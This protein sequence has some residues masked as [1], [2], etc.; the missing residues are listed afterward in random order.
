MGEPVAVRSFSKINLGLRIGPPRADGFHHLTTLFQTVA[1]HDVVTVH[2]E[3]AAATEITLESNDPRVPRDARNTAFRMVAAALAAM[4]L[5][6]RVHVHLQKN[7]PPQGG[8]GAGSAN[9]AA[10]LLGLERQI[11]EWPASGLHFEDRGEEPILPRKSRERMGHPVHGSP[12]SPVGHGSTKRSLSGPERLRLA[13]S[14]GSDV[15][16]FLVG[17]TVYAHNRGELV[18]PYPDLPLMPCVVVSPGVGSSTPLAFRAWDEHMARLGAE[19]GQAR[20]DESS[21]VYASALWE[22]G[23][24]PNGSA[25][26]VPAETLAALVRLGIANDFEEVVFP[27]QPLLRTIKDALA[28]DGRAVLAMLSGSGSSLFGLY[29]S[30]A[31]AEEAREKVLALGG[32]VRAFVTHTVTRQEYWR[33][34]F[35]DSRGG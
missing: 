26:S 30:V 13:E 20:L 33:K 16:M 5:T 34:M 3:P 2:A 14:V 19:A 10:A 21:R 24:G 25:E 28:L 32:G 15:P 18:M 7:L 35:A 1:L 23:L 4:S 9:A 8:M 11:A 22:A 29:R 12:E 6:A 17:G 27:Q 31:D